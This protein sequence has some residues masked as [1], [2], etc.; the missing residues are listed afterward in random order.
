[1]A[2]DEIPIQLL[3]KLQIQLMT[4]DMLEVAFR[5]DTRMQCEA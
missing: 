2:H 5:E 1:M 3:E 4:E